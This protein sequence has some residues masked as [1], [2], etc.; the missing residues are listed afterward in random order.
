MKNAIYILLA[1]LLTFP[2]SVTAKTINEGDPYIS[3]SFDISGLAELEMKTAGA[4]IRVEAWENDQILVEVFV[5]RNGKSVNLS[6]PE[7]AEKL[8]DFDFEIVQKDQK[9]FVAMHS[10]SRGGWNMGRN[11]LSFTFEIFVPENTS[12]E[13][14]SAGGSIAL[15]GLDGNH[16]VVSSGGSIRVMDCAGSFNAKSAGGSFSVDRFVGAM[17]ISS[18]GGSIKVND[19]VGGVRV[20]SSGGSVSLEDIA[21]SLVANTS[22]G[23]IKANLL[24]LEGEVSLKSSG[25]GISAIL[26]R[27]EGLDLDLKGTSSKMRLENFEGEIRGNA[28]K[29][30]LNGGGIPVTMASAGGSV[31]LEFK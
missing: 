14:K 10:K 9:V 25:G 12:A 20:N 5:K 22:G 2:L 17:E 4:S 18:S 16:E 21:G 23:S 15:S 19:L 3:E 13:L 11:Q 29:G 1:C 27:G 7:V 26:P 24:S 6:D 31:K 30:K 8:D 28:I